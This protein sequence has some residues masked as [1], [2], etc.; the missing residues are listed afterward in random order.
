MTAGVLFALYEMGEQWAG[1]G[2]GESV[3]ATQLDYPFMPP[4]VGTEEEV[5]ALAEYLSSLAR[6]GGGQ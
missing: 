1:L 3:D 5:L 4:V 2:A 6:Q